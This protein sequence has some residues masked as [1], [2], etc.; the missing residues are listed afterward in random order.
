[1]NC[2]IC[3]N[4][5]IKRKTTVSGFRVMDFLIWLKADKWYCKKHMNLKI[6]ESDDADEYTNTV[7]TAILGVASKNIPLKSI[8]LDLHKQPFIEVE[9]KPKGKHN[10]FI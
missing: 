10:E 2:P 9:Y 5:L 1:M 3:G 8:L 4:Q 7:K 6:M